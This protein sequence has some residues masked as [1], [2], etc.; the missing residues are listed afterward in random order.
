MELMGC[1]SNTQNNKKNKLKKR[2]LN[3]DF[4]LR[5]TLLL[6][7]ISFPCCG[8]QQGFVAPSQSFFELAVE[9][10]VVNKW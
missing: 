2:I 9:I 10:W 1:K 5:S 4:F 8:R 7:D 3:L 6:R